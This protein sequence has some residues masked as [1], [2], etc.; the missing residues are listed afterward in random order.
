MPATAAAASLY[1]L[2]LKNSIKILSNVARIWFFNIL[3]KF[4]YFLSVSQFQNKSAYKR[5]KLF[6][7]CQYAL[8]NLNY[9]T[10]PFIPFKQ[11]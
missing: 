11:N 4:I 9:I 7:T 6:F 8:Y 3:A 1:G 2:G 5:Y 10:F